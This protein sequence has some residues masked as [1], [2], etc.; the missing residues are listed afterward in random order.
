MKLLM[1]SMLCLAGCSFGAGDVP[2]PQKSSVNV[3]NWS[4]VPKETA[5][6]MSSV[7]TV[8][9]LCTVV[10]ETDTS[11]A[12]PSRDDWPGKR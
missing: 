8:R 9:M 5:P 6:Q 11:S 3:I 4:C 7:G 10:Y 12:L 2:A 1:L